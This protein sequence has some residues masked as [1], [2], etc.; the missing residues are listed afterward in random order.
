MT[1]PLEASHATPRWLGRIGVMCCYVLRAAV[2]CLLA[3][4]CQSALGG[5]I[6]AFNHAD[7][8]RAVRELRLAAITGVANEDGP[9]RDLYTG[10]T[11]L[12]LGNTDGAVAH[13]SRARVA[14]DANPAC[15]THAERA[16]LFGAWRALGKMPG[17]SLAP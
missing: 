15:F 2:L 5:G 14:F 8:P 3:S 9:R 17:Q 1:K 16:R 6:D 4:G 7:Y 13:L 11:H 12:A 10:L